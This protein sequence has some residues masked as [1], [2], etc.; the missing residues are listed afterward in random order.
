[1]QHHLI[2]MNTVCV[3][4]G[5]QPCS[6]V[7]ETF[8]S[9]VLNPS[10]AKCTFCEPVTEAELLDIFRVPFEISAAAAL[11]VFLQENGFHRV[12]ASH[13]PPFH[14]ESIHISTS[15]TQNAL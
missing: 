6:S 8:L 10:N 2:F 14:L 1:M 5:I 3:Q 12:S 7:A 15:K 11:R 9:Q 4:T 13:G